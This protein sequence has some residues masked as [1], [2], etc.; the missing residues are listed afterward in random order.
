MERW[1]HASLLAAG[2]S[3]SRAAAAPLEDQPWGTDFQKHQS[4]PSEPDSPPG[5]G[6]ALLDARTFRTQLEP[7]VRHSGW[8]LKASGAGPHRQWRRR[9]VYVSADRLCYTPDPD[10]DS[11]LCPVRY[12]PLDR[13]PVRALPRGYGPKL[14]V[15]LVEDRQARQAVVPCC[16]VPWAV[17]MLLHEYVESMEGAAHFHEN[18]DSSCMHALTMRRPA[19]PGTEVVQAPSHPLHP[20]LPRRTAPA[21]SS[22]PRRRAA[23]SAW[24]AARTHTSLRHPQPQTP[25]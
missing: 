15:T 7:S 24:P 17:S 22:A 20:S 13:I 5:E 16:R 14:G 21:P 3:P 6:W 25:R 2:S 12:L 11:G 1:D 19:L 23:C 8:L 4:E 9:Y 18:M 10:A